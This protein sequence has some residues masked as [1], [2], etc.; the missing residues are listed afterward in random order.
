M[1]DVCLVESGGKLL[2]VDVDISFNGFL[3]RIGLG[4]VRWI[5]DQLISWKYVQPLSVEDAVVTDQ[6]SLSL[7]RKRILDLPSED[8]ADVLEELSGQEQQA[9]FT[10]LDSEKA[11]ETLMETEPRAQR[12][13]I[14]S[15]RKERARSVFSELTI[16]QLADLFTVI[17]HDE[18]T[19]LMELLPEDQ[20]TRVRAIL[21]KD[22]TTAG[23]ILSADFMAVPPNATVGNILEEIRLS[24]REPGSIS[25]IYVT[26]TD[27]ILLGVVDLRELVLATDAVTLGDIMNSP[28]VA[29][30]DDDVRTDLAAM[31][32]KYHYRMIPVVDSQD[33]LLG[34]IR[35]NDIMK[36]VEIRVKE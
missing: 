6:L 33:H 17:P 12:Q 16:A 5:K 1:N 26:D 28:A 32:A 35:Y 8:L 15:L 34:T 24:G 20:A 23:S 10:S 29:A 9:F 36:G 31:F 21:A 2:L 25:Y 4:K 19:G 27:N 14:A 30:E 7:T 22:E 13:I 18:V 3:R 11:A